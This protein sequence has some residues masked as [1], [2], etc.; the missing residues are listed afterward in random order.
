MPKVKRDREKM[1]RYQA[2]YRKNNLEKCRRATRKWDMGKRKEKY[3]KDPVKYLWGVAKS[4]AKKFGI[5]F[6]ILPEDIVLNKYCP[7]TGRELD[8]FTNNI[9]TSM[10]LDKVVN[11]KGY[12]KGNVQIISRKGNTLK[13][14]GTIE[15]F[16][17]IVK[18]ME[19]NNA[20]N[21]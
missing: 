3:R 10:S 6:E 16:K 19:D 4:R 5:P 2:K 13:N 12:I 18:Y 9:L 20:L 21:N 14:N 8:I 15:Q 17:N 1:N 11:D 7:I